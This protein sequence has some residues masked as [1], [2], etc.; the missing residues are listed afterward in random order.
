MHVLGH[1]QKHF[2]ELMHLK[3]QLLQLIPREAN[4]LTIGYEGDKFLNV[5]ITIFNILGKVVFSNPG[6]YIAHQKT[7]DIS[8]LTAGIYFVEIILEGKE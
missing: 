7:I 6:E 8:R 2:T 5:G 4:E 1:G 3:F